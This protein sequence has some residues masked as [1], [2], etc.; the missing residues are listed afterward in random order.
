MSQFLYVSDDPE[1]F[2]SSG[3]L[4]EGLIDGHAPYRVYL[5]HVNE[6]GRRK[7]VVV[8]A[9]NLSSSDVTLSYS[10]A[11]TTGG[12]WVIVGHEATAGYLQANLT[13]DVQSVV[14]PAGSQHVLADADLDIGQN[15]CGIYDLLLAP[16]HQ[17][18]M[19]VFTCDADTDP[20]AAEP[21]LSSLGSDG[22]QRKGLFDISAL[23]VPRQIDYIVE[24]IG[25]EF[26]FGDG[27]APNL[28]P[29]HSARLDGEYGVVKT[30]ECALHNPTG[31]DA[32]VALYQR[33]A[34]GLATATYYLDG[35]FELLGKTQSDTV[36]R[37]KR[38]TVPAGSA[39]TATIVA[40]T[41]LNSMAPIA[42]RFG[43]ENAAIADAPQA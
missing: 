13:N 42:L 22:K 30:F 27:H 41:D 18:K 5:D 17:L 36:H 35:A 38:Y 1:T 39:L 26:K 21:R 15:A 10:G 16:V 14:I 8:Q 20:T 34:G 24:T 32:V 19:V 28:M 3:I 12:D 25:A 4:L 40:M 11:V 7:K 2:H 9:R 43:P 37:L 29:H 33:T 23:S 31:A 6:A